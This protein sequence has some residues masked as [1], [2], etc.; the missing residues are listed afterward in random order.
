MIKKKNGKVFHITRANSI[1][2][3][4]SITSMTTNEKGEVYIG[5]QQGMVRYDNYAFLL[6]QTDNSDLTSN[7][8]N[9]LLCPDGV[10][11]FAGTADGTLTVFTP[12]GSRHYKGAVHGTAHL[13]AIEQG[14][15]KGPVAVYD[16]E[17]KYS[18]QNQ[19]LV[20]LNLHK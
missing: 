8:I 6:I 16:N 15:L 19:Q 3:S 14:A 1:F 5:T 17:E 18:L 12:A 20:Q 11:I 4:D 7:K 2:P 10:Q 9:S 13:V